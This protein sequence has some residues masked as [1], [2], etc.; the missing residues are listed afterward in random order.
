MERSSVSAGA[1]SE[2]LAPAR[3]IVVGR[4]PLKAGQPRLLSLQ[5]IAQDAEAAEELA[6]YRDVSVNRPGINRT[7]AKL[8][9][10]TAFLLADLPRLF[11]ETERHFSELRKRV[12]ILTPDPFLNAAVGALNV[13]ADAVWDGPEN[14]IMHGAIAWRT[15]LLGWR[16]PYAL[17]ALGWHDRARANLTYWAGRQN[18]DPISEKISPPDEGSNLARN[19]TGLHTNGDLSNSH[20]DMNL[21][22]I[23]ALFRHLRWT[24]DLEYAKKMWPVTIEHH[25]CVGT[26]P[27][28][29]RIRTGKTSALRSVCRHLGE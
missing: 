10:A 11:E 3:P 20:Y 19:E 1:A 17:D 14:A 29:S 12:E 2:K 5:R 16:G 18:D 22:Y 24:G 28:P 25:P 23:D 26:T 8:P 21:V 9:L 27:L 6:T 13:A 4:V 15:K 7:P